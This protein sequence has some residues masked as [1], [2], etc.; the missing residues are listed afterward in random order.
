MDVGPPEWSVLWEPWN[1]SEFKELC[2]RIM[3][4]MRQ[5]LALAILGSACNVFAGSAQTVPDPRMQPPTEYSIG[6]GDVLQI[7][8]WKE[9]DFSGSFFVRYDGRITMPLVGDI[10]VAGR[11]PDQLSKQLEE[12]IGRFV[13]LARVSVSIEEP[14]S[15]Q[16]FVL[17]KVAQ[18]GVFPYTRPIR[19]AQALALAGGLQEFAKLNQIFVIRDVDGRLIYFPF[20][21]NDFMDK[22]QLGGNMVLQ[23][24]DT[25]VVP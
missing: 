13:E 1:F 25:I 5:M 9:A 22:R 8:T 23:P 4:V 16:F 2:V 20:N 21:Y 7:L 11:T 6:A 10:L 17:G 12:N 15:A 24:G 3:L 14:N 18:Q 19:I